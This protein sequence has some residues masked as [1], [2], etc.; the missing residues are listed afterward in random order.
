MV[1]IHA[2]DFMAFTRQQPFGKRVADEPVDAED[3]HPGLRANARRSP[4]SETNSGHEVDLPRELRPRAVDVALDLRGSDLERSMRAL[5]DQR[6]DRENAARQAGCPDCGMLCRF[7]DVDPRV[8]AVRE[9]AGIGAGHRPHQVPDCTA[10][11]LPVDRAVVRA[12]PREVAGVAVVLRNTR[13]TTALDPRQILVEHDA[14]RFDELSIQHARRIL[15]ADGDLHLAHDVAV[16]RSLRHVVESHPGLAF[17][18][19]DRPVDWA[20]APIL[21]QQRAVQVEASGLRNVQDGC[22]QQGTVVERK[23]DVRFEATDLL[24]HERVV[25][26]VGSEHRQPVLHAE[27]GDGTKP[28]RFAGIV[29]V[30]EHRGDFETIAQHCLDARASHL[31]IGN[32]HCAHQRCSRVRRPAAARATGRM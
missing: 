11:R 28:Q 2:M 12:A 8:P 25:Y 24:H 10:G 20:S 14:R 1:Q 22:L 13:S 26:I 6:I 9:C 32:Y 17:T 21:R 15:R 18:V 19:D 16:V 7:P 31:V 23:Q 27:L 5:N 29:P 3:Q 4:G 30:S